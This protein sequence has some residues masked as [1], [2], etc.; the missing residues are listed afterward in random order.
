[1]PAFAMNTFSLSLF[2]KNSAAPAR[3]ESS[4]S[5]SIFTNSMAPLPE[6]FATMSFTTASPFSMSRTVRNS[7]AP[8][9]CSARAVSIPMPLEQP[10]I[11]ITF[12]EM[13]PSSPLSLTICRAVGRASPG[14]LGDACE[15]A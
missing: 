2:L 1:M 15:A 11:S 12:S 13:A 8:V 9:S 10:V 14:P 7:R 3:T 5:S 4:E 6:L